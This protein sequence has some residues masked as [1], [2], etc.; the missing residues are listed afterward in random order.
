MKINKTWPFNEPRVVHDELTFCEES[1]SRVGAELLEH[2][3]VVF[4][5]ISYC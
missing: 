2:L 1:Y 4:P 3:K 5:C